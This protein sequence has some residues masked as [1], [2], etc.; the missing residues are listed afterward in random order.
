M[1]DIE[2]VIEHFDVYLNSTYPS[3]TIE[4]EVFSPSNILRDQHDKYLEALNKYISGHLKVATVQ[5]GYVTYERLGEW[6]ENYN[7]FIVNTIYRGG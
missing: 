3:L 4:G 2:E 5:K 6:N 1:L 7:I